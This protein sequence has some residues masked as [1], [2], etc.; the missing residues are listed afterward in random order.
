MH[1]PPGDRDGGDLGLGAGHPLR[2]RRPRRARWRGAATRPRRACVADHPTRFGAFAVLP[3]PDVK[4]ALLEL[5]HALDVLR[6][7]G[8]VLLAQPQRRHAT[9]AIPPSTT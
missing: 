1:G 4:G 6:L 9:R 3:L 5:E 7:D 8:V 2:R